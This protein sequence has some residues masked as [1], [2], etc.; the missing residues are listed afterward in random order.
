MILDDWKGILSTITDLDETIGKQIAALGDHTLNE[1]DRK[2][3]ELWHRMN[4]SL[5]LAAEAREQAKVRI[6][7]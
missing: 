1:V 4:I 7:R 6:A 2:M 5:R 3:E